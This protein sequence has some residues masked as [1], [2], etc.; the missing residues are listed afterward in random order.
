MRLFILV[1][2]VASFAVGC[3][4]KKSVQGAEIPASL[5]PDPL[6]KKRIRVFD[7]EGNLI[8]SSK[9]VFGV[10][11]PV[12]L[13]KPKNAEN[14][15]VFQ[16]SLNSQKLVNFFMGELTPEK[17]EQWKGGAQFV[18]AVPKGKKKQDGLVD[19]TI[20]GTSTKTRIEVI[21]YPPLPK[22]LPTPQEIE[23]AAKQ[24]WLE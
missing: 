20:L 8:A 17:I 1:F 4:K 12:G 19:V 10:R 18:S 16:T 7:E 23:K 6:K 22:F 13:G 14:K 11:M 15:A 9:R 24:E 3:G 21:R 5:K 2:V